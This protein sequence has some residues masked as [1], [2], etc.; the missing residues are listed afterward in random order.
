MR[1]LPYARFVFEVP[2]SRQGAAERVDRSIYPPKPWW[3]FW[4]RRRSGFE[5]EVSLDGFQLSRIIGYRNSFRPV[6]YGR[7]VELDDERTRVEVTLTVH[8]LVVVLCLVWVGVVGS[9]FI[10]AVAT[11]WRSGEAT[12]TLIGLGGMLAFL[13]VMGMIG[14]GIEVGRIRRFILG[15]FGPGYRA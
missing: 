10:T 15:L 14:W 3:S 5:G 12:P 4:R 11:W 6:A 1:L 7:F 8:P 9:G 2:L 13:Y